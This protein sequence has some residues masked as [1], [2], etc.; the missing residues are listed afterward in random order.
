MVEKNKKEIA[1]DTSKLKQKI[2]IVKERKI[3]T[4]DEELE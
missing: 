4:I 3:I 2:I 1:N